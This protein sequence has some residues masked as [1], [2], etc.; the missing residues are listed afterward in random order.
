MAQPNRTK[1][2][3]LGFLSWGK[4]SGYDLGQLIAGSISNFWSESHGR[5][6]PILAQLAE[7]GLA[8]RTETVSEGGRLRHVYSITE[9][10]RAAF[11]A[12]L[13]E[14]VQPRPPRNELLLKLF[15]GARTDVTASLDRVEE[16]RR[17]G[18]AKLEH[19]EAIRARLESAPNPPP[20]RAWWLMTLRYGELDTRAHLAWCEEV[21]PALRAEQQR[22]GEGSV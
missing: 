13:H 12:W 5:I 9:R 15:F 14:P 19:Y 17:E 18:L 11:E 16:F 2:A 8:T 6:Y 22:K 21:L 20:D 4:L 3:L 7:E 10:G 1:H